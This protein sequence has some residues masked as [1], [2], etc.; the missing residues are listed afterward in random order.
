[1][2]DLERKMVLAKLERIT[3]LGS[4]RFKRAGEVDFEYA[5]R[6]RV[7]AVDMALAATQ[8]QSLIIW[9]QMDEIDQAARF[10]AAHPVEETIIPAAGNSEPASPVPGSA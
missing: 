7:L 4:Q 10:D 5:L 9:F 8:A 2:T 3:E 6:M 1:M